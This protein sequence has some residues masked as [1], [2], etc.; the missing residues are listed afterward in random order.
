MNTTESTI[1]IIAVVVIFFSI[2]M[3]NYLQYQE[4]KRKINNKKTQAKYYL[5]Q[6]SDENIAFVGL[7]KD[8]NVIWGLK[9]TESEDTFYI[10]NTAVKEVITVTKREEKE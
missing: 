9:L 1:L 6:K 10:D 7:T 2:V 3:L 5:A 4:K 8:D